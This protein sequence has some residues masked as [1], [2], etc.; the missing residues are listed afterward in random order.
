[1]NPMI[2]PPVPACHGLADCAV[3]GAASASMNMESCKSRERTKFIMMAMMIDGE[4]DRREYG[5][6]GME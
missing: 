4:L 5:F 1:M 3:M 2:P 6:R